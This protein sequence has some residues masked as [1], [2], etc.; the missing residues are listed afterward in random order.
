MMPAMLRVK[1]WRWSTAGHKA[2]MIAFNAGGRLVGRQV[3]VIATT[4]SR[5]SA[6]CPVA[7]C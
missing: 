1:I 4:G 3:T 2:N 5:V 6:L 7:P